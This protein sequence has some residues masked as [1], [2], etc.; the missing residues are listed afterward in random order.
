M[1]ARGSVNI[2]LG[3]KQALA[4]MVGAGLAAFER[5]GADDPRG[6]VEAI[7]RAAVVA[8]RAATIRNLKASRLRTK[9]RW[10]ESLA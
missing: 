2:N 7:I 6:M 9:A 5:V 1:I 8:K 10:R 3:D 4:E